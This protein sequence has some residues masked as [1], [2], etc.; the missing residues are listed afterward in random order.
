MPPWGT[1]LQIVKYCE[2]D[3]LISVTFDQCFT[4]NSKNTHVCRMLSLK[5]K[6]IVMC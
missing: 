1:P 3:V 5:S 4:F 2:I 6:L